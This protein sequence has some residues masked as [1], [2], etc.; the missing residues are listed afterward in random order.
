MADGTEAKEL[1][2]CVVMRGNER[3]DPTET[4]DR[5]CRSLSAVADE[6]GADLIGVNVTAVDA[7]KSPGPGFYESDADWGGE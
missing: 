1:R 2:I 7:D 5:L 3:L 6:V 4:R